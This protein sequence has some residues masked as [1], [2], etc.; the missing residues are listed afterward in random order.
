[1]PQWF[2]WDKLAIQQISVIDKVHA[3]QILR[4]IDRL[5]V[6]LGDI[7]RL[8]GVEPAQFRL[9]VGDYRVLFRP[10]GRFFQHQ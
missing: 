8:Q 7:E 9:V 1:M 3:L 2:H 6:G 4:A 5:R 10:H